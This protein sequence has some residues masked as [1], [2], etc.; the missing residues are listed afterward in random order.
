MFLKVCPLMFCS[1]FQKR[2]AF[3]LEQM[4][5]RRKFQPRHL[6]LLAKLSGKLPRVV[7][8][9]STGT[10][11]CKAA[12]SLTS[13]VCLSCRSTLKSSKP[14]GFQ[15]L[16]LSDASCCFCFVTLLGCYHAWFPPARRQPPCCS[17]KLQNMDVTQFY[18]PS[19]WQKLGP[20]HC[21]QWRLY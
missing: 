19:L 7:L 9:Y 5:A 6:L 10:Q 2:H 21:H 4:I 12:R 15:P 3:Y 1:I 8:P 13:Q 11:P 16:P 20:S 17:S 14:K 18:F